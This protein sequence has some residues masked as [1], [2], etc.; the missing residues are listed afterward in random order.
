MGEVLGEDIIE[1]KMHRGAEMKD[2]WEE[3][4]SRRYIGN[5]WMKRCITQGDRV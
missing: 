3:D 5:S 1:G 4:V 2:E